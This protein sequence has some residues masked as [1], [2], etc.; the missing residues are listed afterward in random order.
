MN[1]AQRAHPPKQQLHPP[2]PSLPD[3]WVTLPAPAGQQLVVKRTFRREL[4]APAQLRHLVP[5]QR[6]WQPGICLGPRVHLVQHNTESKN[7]AREA[8]LAV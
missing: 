4:R 7:V 8:E 6:P 3:G 2:Q 5:Q 1:A